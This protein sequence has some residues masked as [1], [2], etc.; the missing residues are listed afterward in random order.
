MTSVEVAKSIIDNAETNLRQAE[1]DAHY[2][3]DSFI[4]DIV[5]P[6]SEEQGCT[7]RPISLYHDERMK[8]VEITHKNYENGSILLY[9]EPGKS[10]TR[11]SYNEFAA[12]GPHG[13][14]LFFCYIDLKN[15]RKSLSDIIDAF[16][17]D[18]YSHLHNAWKNQKGLE[19]PFKFDKDFVKKITEKYN[20]H[21]SVQKMEE[22]KSKGI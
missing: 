2:L 14:R 22:L 9:V 15:P 4:N 13:M 20:L 10:I 19:F 8:G 5:I 6:V 17:G 21:T 12:Q 16:F 1:K 11:F 18:I 3:F 7:V